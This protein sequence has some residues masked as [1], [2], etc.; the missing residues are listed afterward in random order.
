MAFHEFQGWD[1]APNGATH[2]CTQDVGSPWLRRK[3]GVDSFYIEG[4]W[5]EYW[6]Q[7]HRHFIN[8]IE[9]P[10]EA[11]PEEVRVL[12]VDDRVVNRQQIKK[13]V[14]PKSVGWW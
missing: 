10:G 7:P 13:E 12:K 5:E 6:D 11:L 9:R 4:E 8:A 14:A 1:K 2:F 3:D